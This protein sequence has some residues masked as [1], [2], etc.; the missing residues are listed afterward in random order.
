[1]DEQYTINIRRLGIHCMH[2]TFD[3]KL[4]PFVLHYIYLVK[5][6]SALRSI[7]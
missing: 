7:T 5:I 4:K 1:M 6:H 2:N 3:F